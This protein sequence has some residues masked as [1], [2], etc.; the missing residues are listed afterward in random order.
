MTIKAVAYF[1]TSSAANVGDDKDSLTRQKNA[2]ET[3]AKRNGYEIVDDG[4][5]YDAAVKGS[6]P[7]D[8][9][10]GF[11]AML[12]RIAGNGVRTILVE[13]ASRFAR[14]LTV[15]E[16]G[17]RMLSKLG[18]TLISVDSPDA[19]VDDTPTAV[20]VRQ[21][22]GA[23]AEFERAALVMKLKSGRA[24]KARDTG[25][26]CG[27]R[28]PVSELDPAAIDLARNLAKPAKGHKRRSLRSIADALAGAGHLSSA[29]KPY[30][31]A[32]VARMIG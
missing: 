7:V 26:Q 23:V 6:D 11:R 9:R 4:A 29:G 27:G 2:V 8:D 15:Q 17:W 25:L 28:R 1:R 5:F 14:D 13:S 32:V 22:L 12:D 10:P 3:F 31:P 18:I 16:L 24:K 30:N 19:F 20:M 21:I